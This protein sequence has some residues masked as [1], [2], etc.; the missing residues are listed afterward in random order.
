MIPSPCPDFFVVLLLHL[1]IFFNRNRIKLT[2]MYPC[3]EE[4]NFIS[5]VYL[6]NPVKSAGQS[7]A[8]NKTIDVLTI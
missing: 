1:L 4:L 8:Q 6:N 7:L 2:T 5:H 3:I